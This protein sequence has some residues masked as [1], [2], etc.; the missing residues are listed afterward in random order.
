MLFRSTYEEAV[1]YLS[2]DKDTRNN[3]GLMVNRMDGSSKFKMEELP[4]EVA[5]IADKLEVGDISAP[6]IMINEKTGREDVAIIKLKNRIPGHKA[7]VY[8]DFQEL[9]DMLENQKREEILKEFI[10]KK[11]QETY[12]RIKEGWANCEFQYPGWIKN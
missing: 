3:N 9:K 12:I 6:F 5:R 1:L 11:Q 10:K 4:S 7:T 2:N 8:D